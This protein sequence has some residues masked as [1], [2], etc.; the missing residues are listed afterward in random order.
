[1]DSQ[2]AIDQEAIA[3]MGMGMGDMSPLT[4]GA[5][6]SA[7][8]Q[9]V[10]PVAGAMKMPSGGAMPASTDD[11]MMTSAPR[12]EVTLTTSG[13]GHLGQGF[14][15][16]LTATFF[17]AG[18]LTSEGQRRNESSQG[19]QAGLSLSHRIG[20]DLRATLTGGYS[21]AFASPGEMANPEWM[22]IAIY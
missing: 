18:S 14:D 7:S 19:G 3:G 20:Q 13:A 5:T 8:F 21:L 9:T 12:Y 16:G 15:Y 4:N 11:S 22:F 6:L 2:P 17:A 10:F 1:A